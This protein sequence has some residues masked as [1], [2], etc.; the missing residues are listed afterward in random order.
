MLGERCS[1]SL[2]I[3]YDIRSL[4]DDGE[5]HDFVCS[6]RLKSSSHVLKIEGCGLVI[7]VV[8]RWTPVYDDTLVPYV[9]HHGQY[10]ALDD[11]DCSPSSGTHLD[12]P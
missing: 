7:Y 5:A 3:G 6:Y 8:I 2:A 11:A 10:T 4:V 1:P 9:V 12:L